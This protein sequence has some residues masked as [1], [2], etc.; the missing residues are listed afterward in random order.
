MLAVERPALIDIIYR[1]LNSH[2]NIHFAFTLNM[3][4]IC[5]MEKMPMK[6]DLHIHT[7]ISPC[8]S[9]HF[10]DILI[11]AQ[12]AGLD[13]VCLTDHNTMRIRKFASEG[14]QENGLYVFIGMEYSTPQ[15]DFLLF[16]PFQD[17]PKDLNAKDVLMWADRQNG[18]AVAAHPFRANRQVSEAVVKNGH[19]RIAEGLNGRNSDIENLR[20]AAWKEKYHIQLT[21]G[22]DAHEPH[23]VGKFYTCFEEPVHSTIELVQALKTGTYHP[24]TNLNHPI[25]SNPSSA[26]SNS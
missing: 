4:N 6:I 16:G 19:C 22:S 17:V 12:M 3:N 14:I 15:G 2:W 24:E 13:G 23:E 8:S 21:G 20:A 11:Y 9:M 7:D 10:T 5:F 25:L 18:A 1:A 26:C